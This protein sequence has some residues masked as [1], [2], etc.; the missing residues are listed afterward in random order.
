PMAVLTVDRPSVPHP[1]R[2]IPLLGDLLDVD[3]T[4]PTQN[5]MACARRLGPIYQRKIF[6]Y[7]FTFVSGVD[8][9]T[10]LNDESRFQKHV[11]VALRNLRPIGNDGLFTA[12]NSEPNWSK[13]H[14]I[15]MPAFT[16]FAMRSY[17]Q[18]MLDT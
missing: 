17:H 3:V 4:K 9:A 14:N 11:G 1:P 7:V 15:L 10:E 13:A 8:L 2:R 5:A 18:T 12:Y 6:N 16:Q